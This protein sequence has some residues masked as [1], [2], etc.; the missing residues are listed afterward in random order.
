MTI[1]LA[2]WYMSLL[3]WWWSRWAKTCRNFVQ[4]IISIIYGKCSCVDCCDYYHTLTTYSKLSRSASIVKFIWRVHSSIVQSEYLALKS[5]CT[6]IFSWFQTFSMFWMLYAFFW[7]NPRHLN[8][9]CRHFGTLFHLQS[10]YLALKSFGTIIFSWFQ[11][12]AMF[13]MLYAFFWVNPQRLNFI[14]RR[15]G[16]LFHLHRRA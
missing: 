15:F 2:F 6:I 7:V 10:E 3:A 12:F 11:T 16:T 4:T 14:C 8:F 5:F 9:I 1:H 13:W